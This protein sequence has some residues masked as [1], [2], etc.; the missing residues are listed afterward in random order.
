MHEALKAKVGGH[1]DVAGV[2]VFDSDGMLINSSENWPPPNINIADRAY[3]KAAKS[4]AATTPVSI[5]LV[6]GRLSKDWATVIAY[7]ITGPNGEFLGLVTRAI[8]PASFEKF[9][10][11]LALGDGASI[12]IYHR[13]GTLLARYPHVQAMIGLNFKNAPVHQQIL[14]KSDH[15][16]TRID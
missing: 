9:F 8:T 13:D 6:Q 12:A 1:S 2:N 10:E 3:F 7:K 4:G 14:S 15:G 16:T 11:S 5:E